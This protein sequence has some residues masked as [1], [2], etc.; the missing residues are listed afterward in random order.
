MKKHISTTISAKH[1]ELLKKHTE[2]FE[3]QQKVLEAALELLDSSSNS[4]HSSPLSPELELQI[5]N[6]KEL[7]P[8][9]L[10][11]RH[12]LKALIDIADPEK[13]SAIA[14]TYKYTVEFIEY[15]YQKPFGKLSL[16]EVLDGL[17]IASMTSNWFQAANYTENEE[18]Y[19]LRINHSLGINGSKFSRLIIETLFNAYGAKTESEMSE[20]NIFIKIYK[21]I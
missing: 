14:D 20:R 1:W 17:L 7:K 12:G 10:I 3:T 19:T 6:I 8:I 18:Y 15:N 11:P 16:K 9:C 4:N 5:K 21:K 13:L 2:K